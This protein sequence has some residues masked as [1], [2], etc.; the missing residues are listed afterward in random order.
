MA[1]NSFNNIFAFFRPSFVLLSCLT[2]FFLRTMAFNH[3]HL[4]VKCPHNSHI[5]T[6]YI[7]I[8]FRHRAFASVSLAIV[9]P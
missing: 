7:I 2:P 3:P 1:L 5:G 4:D 9:S 8:A 6:A